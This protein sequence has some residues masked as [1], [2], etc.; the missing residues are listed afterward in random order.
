[1]AA[2]VRED[3]CGGYLA[4]I[5]PKCSAHSPLRRVSLCMTSAARRVVRAYQGYK[6]WKRCT[7]DRSASFSSS[8]GFSGKRENVV[9][10]TFQAARP[11]SALSSRVSQSP[12]S[13]TKRAQMRPSILGTYF[14][15]A[16]P[17]F[18]AIACPV[19]TVPPVLPCCCP[20]CDIYDRWLKGAW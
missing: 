19:S 10:S 7:Y 12:A 11:S 9:C 1:M 8:V 2:A 6:R 5:C 14:A 4:R 18:G 3:T 13:T 16:F 17:S 15:V 20:G